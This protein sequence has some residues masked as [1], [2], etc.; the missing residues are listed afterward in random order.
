MNDLLMEQNHIQKEGLFLAPPESKQVLLSMPS[1]E[2]EWKYL[3]S[4]FDDT[5]NEFL[6][7]LRRRYPL[8]NDDIHLIILICLGVSNRQI[9]A[10]FHIR[11]TSLATHRYRIAKKM[12]L[13]EVK[14]I[15]EAI[16]GMLKKNNTERLSMPA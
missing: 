16:I 13:K 6:K 11:L 15:N 4:Y 5:Y 8:S 7:K 1:N 14:S 3:E 2:A 10:Y 9:A 12:G